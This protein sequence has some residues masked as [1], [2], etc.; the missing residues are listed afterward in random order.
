MRNS[1]WGLVFVTLLLSLSQKA[2]PADSGL[3]TK[4]SRYSVQETIERF[5][6][7]VK[8]K[9][10]TVFGEVD[11]AAAATKVGLELRPRT[12]I[13]FG[14]PQN[15]T[16]AL[17]AAPTLAIDAPMKAL[18]WQDNQGKVWLTYNSAEYQGGY[19]YPRHGLS[20]SADSRK[21]LEEFSR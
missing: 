20:L 18:V 19:I 17:R 5:E 9:G 8:A 14:R 10:Q 4:P 13:L 11:H 16:A 15:G 6:T 1:I 7:A 12:V 3:I 2:S 21:N